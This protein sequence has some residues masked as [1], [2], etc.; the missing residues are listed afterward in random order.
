MI[1]RIKSHWENVSDSLWFVPGWCILFLTGLA[2]V[3]PEVDARLDDRDF[4]GIFPGDANAAQTIL[5]VVAGSLITVVSLVFSIT[6]LVLQ[7]A[8]QQYTPRLIGNFMAFRGVQV[9]LGIFLGTFLYALL[10]LR[11]VRQDGDGSAEYVPELSVTGALVLSGLCSGLLVYFLHHTAVSIEV[12]AV[13]HRVAQQLHDSI[14]SHYPESGTAVEGDDDLEAF[15]ARHPDSVPVEIRA[16][17]S[18]FVRRVDEQSIIEA[19]GNAEWVAIRTRVG[20]YIHHGDL[21]IEIGGLVGLDDER[22]ERLRAGIALDIE[23]SLH[24]DP[25]FGIRQL[26]DI[27]LRALSPAMNDPTTAEYVLS[28]LGDLL[29]ALGRQSYSS[30][31]RLVNQRE[32]DGQIEL[33]ADRA[34][35][36]DF[37]DAAFSQ[38]RRMAEDGKPHVT[39]HL[40]TVIAAVGRNLNASHRLGALRHQV[41]EIILAIDENDLSPTD[42]ETLREK[43]NAVLDGMTTPQDRVV[44]GTHQADH[45]SSLAT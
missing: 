13:T 10:I 7:Q 15:R 40:L 12:P 45:G 3:M 19:A 24:Q 22:V 28:Q 1:G 2:F 39:A 38:I 25:L 23:R 35:F 44:A 37:V 32:D 16:V 8:S 36:S 4:S 18:G 29:I 21:L 9:V 41:A 42:R 14:E 27:A 43:A 5:Q 30:R 20:S 31:I 6:I 34:M 11:F 26:V 33:W 17:H